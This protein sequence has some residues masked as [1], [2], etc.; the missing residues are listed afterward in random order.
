MIIILW[1]IAVLL[2]FIYL[3]YFAIPILKTKIK[4][5]LYSRKVRK[6]ANKS[7]EYLEYITK[8]K[9][10]NNPPVDFQQL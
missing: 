7:D 6:M 3:R 5:Y 1:V 9:E 10:S 8:L 2:L 4:F